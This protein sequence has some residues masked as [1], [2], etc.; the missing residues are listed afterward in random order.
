[1]GNS[2]SHGDGVSLT[3]TRTD[4]PWWQSAVDR[5]ELVCFIAGRLEFVPGDPEFRRRSRSGAPSCLLAFGEV[6]A[7]AVE[8]AELGACL[9]RSGV[10]RSQGDLL[11]S[12]R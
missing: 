1:M 2:P 8:R 5:A 12:G 9:R 7:A 6:C 4:T 10:A 3:F 11:A